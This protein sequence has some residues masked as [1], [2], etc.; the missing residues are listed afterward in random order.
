[1]EDLVYLYFEQLNKVVYSINLLTPSFPGDLGKIEEEDDESIW[2]YGEKYDSLT[3]FLASL[4]NRNVETHMEYKK[5]YGI[6]APFCMF[7]FLSLSTPNPTVQTTIVTREK[8]FSFSCDDPI[9]EDVLDKRNIMF[10]NSTLTCEDHFDVNVL[11][12]LVI[13]IMQNRVIWPC[14]QEN[15]YLVKLGAMCFIA[16][17]EKIGYDY[18]LKIQCHT[19]Q[20]VLDFYEVERSDIDIVGNVLDNKQNIYRLINYINNHCYGSAKKR[21]SV[22]DEIEMVQSKFGKWFVRCKHGELSD[23]FG[24]MEKV[25][26]IAR[27]EGKKVRGVFPECDTKKELEELVKRIV[28]EI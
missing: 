5:R 27:S 28:D 18:R 23:V 12:K 3:K 19:M 15:R 16:D 14:R 13:A 11:H 25:R 17:L 22:Y 6:L 2:F 1:M 4:H 9:G 21:T 24:D 10:N 26:K 20:D 7:Q 8:L